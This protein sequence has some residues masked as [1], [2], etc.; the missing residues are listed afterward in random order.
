M[1]QQMPIHHDQLHRPKSQPSQ[2]PLTQCPLLRPSLFQLRQDVE[3]SCESQHSRPIINSPQHST[4]YVGPTSREQLRQQPIINSPHLNQQFESN[5]FPWSQWNSATRDRHVETIKPR[6][7]PTFSGD[8]RM[9][10]SWSAAFYTC[11]DAAPATPEYK[12]LQLRSYL[13]G[14]ALQAIERLG[15]SAT[16]YEAA[17]E[18]SLIHI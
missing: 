6:A 14:E 17:K 15:H 5:P 16:A 12:L 9:Y 10:E 18:L 3:T 4:P 1:S 11:V 2:P 7:I 13:R 8:K